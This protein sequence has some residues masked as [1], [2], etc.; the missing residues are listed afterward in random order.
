MIR[1]PPRSTLFPYTTL[2]RSPARECEALRPHAVQHELLHRPRS[3]HHLPGI[4]GALGR[5]DEQ[6][7]QGALP[8]GLFELV[9]PPPVVRE[10]LAVEDRG[11]LEPGI[12]DE[13]EEHLP[14]ERYAFVIVPLPF[15]GA[16]T[17]ADEDEVTV[18]GDVLLGPLGPGDEVVAVAGACG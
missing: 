6:R 8:G 13:H 15:G 7:A 9:G 17:V 3:P 1:R 16:R 5:M 2:F 12:V 14:A 11:V 4:G 10:R 18:D